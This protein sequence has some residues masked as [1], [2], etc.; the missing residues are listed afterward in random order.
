MKKLILLFFCFLPLS[1]VAQKYDGDWKGSYISTLTKRK[2]NVIFH[3][4]ENKCSQESPGIENLTKPT[5]TEMILS[6][7]NDSIFINEKSFGKSLVFK[8]KL[9]KGKL[10]GTYYYDHWKYNVTLTKYGKG[11]VNITRKRI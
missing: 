11:V 7:E 4:V 5:E 1:V 2:T 3:I 9:I 6:Q 8:G 10:I